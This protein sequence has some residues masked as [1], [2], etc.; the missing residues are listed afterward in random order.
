LAPSDQEAFVRQEFGRADFFNTADDVFPARLLAGP[1]F[2]LY[3]RDSCQIFRVAD[4]EKLE[5]REEKVRL[6]YKAG[7]ARIRQKV[8][9]G[10]SLV[11][12][13]RQDSSSDT[14]QPDKLYLANWEQ[15]KTAK[16]L[17]ARHCPKAHSLWKDGAEASE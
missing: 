2:W 5:A 13:Y 10:V 7:G 14:G 4:M 6:H 12:E 8:G 16:E 9:A 15:L 3:F 17:I 11:V 1:D